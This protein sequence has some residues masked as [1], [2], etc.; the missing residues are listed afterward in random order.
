MRRVVYIHVPKCGGSSFGAALR[1]RAFFSQTTIDIAATRKAA[2]AQD[3]NLRGTA[4]IRADYAL[5][6]QALTRAILRGTKVIAAHALD[7]PDLRL[8]P[9]RS[10]LW[11]T[12]LRDPVTRFASHYHYLQRRHPDPARAPSLEAFSEGP[13]AL[14]IGSQC[15][16]YFSGDWARPGLDLAPQLDR[17][18]QAL[19]AYDL[20]GRLEDAAPF[21]CDLARAVGTP[22]PFLTRNRAAAPFVLSAA[23][24]RRIEAVCTADLELFETQFPDRCAA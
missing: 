21:R 13:D 11:V 14:R 1:M 15:L 12:L 9:G 2:L 4:L 7:A 18:R 23:L 6:E 16:F 22:L 10:H 19:D 20:V 5:R 3:P 24:R 8:G 17:A